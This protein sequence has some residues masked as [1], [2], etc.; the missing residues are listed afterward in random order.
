MR[1]RRKSNKGKG[2]GET[3]EREGRRVGRIE[4]GGG[5]TEG[6]N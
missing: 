4:E 3:G 1:R 2:G 6:D 5:V